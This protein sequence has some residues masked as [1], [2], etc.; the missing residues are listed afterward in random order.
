[1]NFTTDQEKINLVK[2]LV[3]EKHISFEDGVKLLQV[4]VVKE[5]ITVPSWNPTCAGSEPHQDGC[6]VTING[7]TIPITYGTYTTENPL[8]NSTFKQ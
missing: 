2:K 5:Y 8:H 6:S 1:M 3:E 7:T 4:E